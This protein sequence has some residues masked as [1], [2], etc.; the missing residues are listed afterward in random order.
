MVRKKN[1]VRTAN[2][3]WLILFSRTYVNG[4]VFYE[5]LPCMTVR[6]GKSDDRSNKLSILLVCATLLVHYYSM[7]LSITISFFS[8]TLVVINDIMDGQR[9]KVRLTIPDC[10]LSRNN[11]WVRSLAQQHAHLQGMKCNFS[12]SSS[13]VP[14]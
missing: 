11:V 12:S 6:R 4:T 14:V 8:L 3:L 9:R 13:C 7:R 1:S 5:Y 2:S 10:S